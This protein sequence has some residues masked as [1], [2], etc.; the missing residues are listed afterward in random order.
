MPTKTKTRKA[1]PAGISFD[2]ELGKL[3]AGARRISVTKAP[4]M[5]LRCDQGTVTLQAQADATALARIGTCLEDF[6][7]VLPSQPFTKWVDSLKATVKMG[8]VNFTVDTEGVLT[9][10]VDHHGVATLTLRRAVEEPLNLKADDGGT[11]GFDGSL[12]AAVKAVGNVVHHD[13]GS[14]FSAVLVRPG[15]KEDGYG[16][17]VVGSDK[18]RIHL[19][20]S[21]AAINFT[22]L[23]P[24]DIGRVFGCFDLGDS[25]ALVTKTNQLQI[26]DPLGFVRTPLVNGQYATQ[27]VS[28]L[29]KEQ[30]TRIAVNRDHLDEML[31]RLG[32]F[33]VGSVAFEVQGDQFFCRVREAEYGEQEETMECEVLCGPTPPPVLMP[34]S[35]PV[36]AL[37]MLAGDR[38]ILG[39]TAAPDHHLIVSIEGDEQRR[40]CFLAVAR[41][42]VTAPVE[43]EEDEDEP[44][45]EPEPEA[46]EAVE[47]DEDEDY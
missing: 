20:R 31:K 2:V 21:S 24:A 14:P 39:Y 47:P 19:A 26:S 28:F 29:E 27:V 12:V 46:A 9:L 34:T 40:R 4:F 16:A 35:S 17:V 3:I 22:A 25:H 32:A 41:G 5:A 42:D 13:I 8:K 45:D 7:T 43:D 36:D 18:K 6:G 30:V 38:V 44:Q 33:G 23:L 1:A 10:R 15:E 37:G 11:V